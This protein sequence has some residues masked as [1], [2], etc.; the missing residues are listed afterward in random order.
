MKCTC[1]CHLLK[2]C[3][4]YQLISVA[5]F[6]QI[7]ISTHVL[8]CCKMYLIKL[9]SCSI[10]LC[11]SRVLNFVESYVRS[12]HSFLA[13]RMVSLLPIWKIISRMFYLRKHTGLIVKSIR[14]IL[15]VNW[16]SHLIL[17]IGTIHPLHILFNFWLIINKRLRCT[18]DFLFL[19][20]L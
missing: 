19:Q 9:I 17:S 18:F 4:S 10:H 15:K 6:W 20:T 11:W 2:T 5:Y 3:M 12:I 7:V 1:W 14:Q 16:N 13:F 8:G